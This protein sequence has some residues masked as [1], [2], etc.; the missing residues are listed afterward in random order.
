MM[1]SQWMQLDTD[2]EI[3]TKTSKPFLVQNNYNGEA[4]LYT[5]LCLIFKMTNINCKRLTDKHISKN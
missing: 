5:L 3:N 2:T 1:K 4:A